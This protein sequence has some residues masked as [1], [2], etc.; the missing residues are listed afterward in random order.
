M[1]NNYEI[2]VHRNSEDMDLKLVGDFDGISAY[3]LLSIL[4]RNC[5]PN[6]SAFMHTSTLKKLHPFRVNV[7]QKDVRIRIYMINGAGHLH[8]SAG[9]RRTLRTTQHSIGHIDQRPA[10]RALSVVL[11]EELDFLIWR[12]RLAR[13]RPLTRG[14]KTSPRYVKQVKAVAHGLR[15]QRFLLEEDERKMVKL[16]EDLAWPPKPMD[17][18]PFWEMEKK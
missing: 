16:A 10:G 17:G 5:N 6:S 12:C 8:P 13:I 11:D 4:K 9:N 3:E 15:M 7:F 14:T 18:P 2:F 1:A